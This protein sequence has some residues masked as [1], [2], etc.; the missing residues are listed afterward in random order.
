MLPWPRIE[1]SRRDGLWGR[2]NSKGT[3]LWS[4]GHG[5]QQ[6]DTPWELPQK[7]L[8]KLREQFPP[9]L[10]SSSTFPGLSEHICT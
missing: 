8:S 7:G 5:L 6:P 2:V 4:R 10:L 3:H 9:A 1:K